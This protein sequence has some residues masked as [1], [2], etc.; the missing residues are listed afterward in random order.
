MFQYNVVE[1]FASQLYQ[2][3]IKIGIKTHLKL[4]YCQMLTISDH[5]LVNMPA[6]AARRGFALLGPNSP[7]EVATRHP[8]VKPELE[9]IQADKE[10]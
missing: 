5:G 6:A 10:G 9:K 2:S 7:Q 1:A 3:N 8:N 4:N